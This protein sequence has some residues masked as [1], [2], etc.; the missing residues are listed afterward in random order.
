[1]RSLLS[2]Y[3]QVKLALQ[4]HHYIHA[5]SLVID[6]HGLLICGKSGFGKTSLMLSLLEQAKANNKFAAMVGDDQS[7]VA[8]EN[9]RLI[10]YCPSSTK[11]KLEIRGHGIVD[12]PFLQ[13]AVINLVIEIVPRENIDRM[14][15]IGTKTLDGIQL[16]LVFV[17]RYGLQQSVQI[18]QAML[19]DLK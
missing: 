6:H 18:I 12:V 3:Q 4:K 17:P 5:N 15:T 9:N 16:P 1:M 8:N 10:A 2:G 19:S 11:G 7:L 14:P 13:S